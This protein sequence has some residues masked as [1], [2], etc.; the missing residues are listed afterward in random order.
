MEIELYLSTYPCCTCIPFRFHFEWASGVMTTQGTRNKARVRRNFHC[1]GVPPSGERNFCLVILLWPNKHFSSNKSPKA[2]DID[3]VA[4]TFQYV[5]ICPH[6][7]LTLFDILRWRRLWR[8]WKKVSFKFASFK[9]H[10]FWRWEL[11]L[12]PRNNYYRICGRSCSGSTYSRIKFSVPAPQ[13]H[14]ASNFIASERR[15]SV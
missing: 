15:R 1:T 5:N 8:H 4:V 2:D 6:L 12:G 7:L 9:Q 10:Q 14:H 3:K 13:Y 11:R